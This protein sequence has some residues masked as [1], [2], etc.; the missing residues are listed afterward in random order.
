MEDTPWEDAGRRPPPP[1]SAST[2]ASR[3][4]GPSASAPAARPSS[5]SGSTTGPRRSTAC[6]P[7]RAPAP[8]SSS[9]SGATSAHSCS[10]GRAAG[11]RVAYPPGRAEKQAREMFPATA[12]TDEPGAE[13]IARTALGMPWTLREVLEEDERRASLRMLSSQR[14]FCVKGRTESRELRA[15]ARARCARRQARRRQPGGCRGAGGPPLLR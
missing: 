11:M 9:I 10:P 8:S 13:V 6:S 4:T 5:A 15:H 12:K 14:A 2:S 3:S 7:R 1:R